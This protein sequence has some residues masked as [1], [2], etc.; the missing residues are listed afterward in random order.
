ML[1][2]DKFCLIL[3]KYDTNEASTNTVKKRE[4]RLPY[5]SLTDSFFPRS[6]APEIMKKTG[7][8][9]RI[10]YANTI[11]GKCHTDP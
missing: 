11:N 9:Q 3:N 8:A 6:K 7:T 1:N 4:T 5:S 10:T 2:W